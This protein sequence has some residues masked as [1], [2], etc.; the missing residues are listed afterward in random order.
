MMG[1]NAGSV[2]KEDAQ[3]FRNF[4]LFCQHRS[5]PDGERLIAEHGLPHPSIS[6]GIEPAAAGLMCR[7]RHI[8]CR[9]PNTT[10]SPGLSRR[11][12][13]G[14]TIDPRNAMPRKIERPNRISIS[15]A[16]IR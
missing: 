14:E 13:T 6:Y 4:P 1:D 15:I 2:A 8:L 7:I 16:P 3:Q 5:T 10:A 11:P 12:V 9:I